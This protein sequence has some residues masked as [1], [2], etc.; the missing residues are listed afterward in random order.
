MDELIKTDTNDELF[1]Q[2]NATIEISGK[3]LEINQTTVDVNFEGILNTIFQY[4]N[5]GDILQKIKVGTEYVVQVPSQFQ[6]GL[7][8]GDFSMMENMK[9]GTMWPALMELGEDGR[10]KIVTPLPIKRH[11]FVQGNPFQELA[12]GYHNLYMQKQIHELAQLLESTLTTVNR[13][14][15]GQKSDR[16]GLLN[17]GKDQLLL[18]LSQKDEGSRN[19]ALQLGRQ[20]LSNARGQFAETF[21]QKVTDFEALPEIQLKQFIRELT[22]KGYLQ[23]K[24]KE[25]QEI[26][27]Y[28]ELYLQATKMLAASY[29]I[30]DDLDNAER[31]FNLSIEYM[32]EIDYRNLKTI[33]FAHKGSE[34]DG[35]FD[36]ASEFIVSEKQ[37]YI[38]DTKKYN[39]VSIEVSGEKLLEVLENGKAE[40]FP[41]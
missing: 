4:I 36:Y 6:F 20:S 31:V 5:I 10:K 2:Q 17:S 11:E 9:T 15:K 33:Q 29:A 25:Y 14:E 41:E 23:R 24:D 13:I 3:V 18:A 37:N 40:K 12:M 28:Y 39:Y 21:K 1:I 32:N 30:T 22:K 26:Q 19:Q 34:F 38:E 35:L 7:E 27:D 8:T 16:I